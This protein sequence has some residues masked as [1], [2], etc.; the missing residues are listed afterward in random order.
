MHAKCIIPQR[1]SWLVL[2][3]LLASACVPDAA[4][5]PPAAGPAPPTD[6]QPP[7]DQQRGGD[8]QQ[9]SAAQPTAEPGAAADPQPG[10]V[11]PAADSVDP[12]A[13][14]VDPADMDPETRALWDQFTASALTWAK[15]VADLREVQIRFHNGGPEQ[16]AALRRQFQQLRAQ[17]RQE[18]DRALADAVALVAHEQGGSRVAGE[19]VLQAVIARVQQDWL[20]GIAR[21]ADLLL[22]LKVDFPGLHSA[23][24]R[25][26]VVEGQY[27]QARP[28]L[29]KAAEL[30]EQAAME[31]GKEPEDRTDAML[32]GMLAESRAQWQ[33][34]Q[35]LR[36]ADAAADDLPRVLLKTT[37]GDVVVELF[38]DQAPNTVANFI[39]L[40]EQGFY[41]ELTF[42]QVL[43]HLFALTG[44]PVGDGSGDAG[45][46]IPD[47]HDR[48]DARDVFRGSLVMAKLPNPAGGTT[49]TLPN[50]ASS[51]FMI[52]FLPLAAMSNEYTVFG[53]VIEG[54]PAVATMTRLNPHEK[55]DEGPQY[56]PDRILSAEVL[57]KRDHPYTVE[58]LPI[59]Q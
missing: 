13:G 44:D 32:L 56:P 43:D 24:G 17:G 28:F 39:T 34:E 10:S 6:Q 31:K 59:Q 27:E 15:T 49:Q 47:E 38:E 5:Q 41:D 48:A 33:R 9:P 25:G 16:A 40:V 46:R 4:A 19:F 20:E 18:Y 29:L 3:A 50:T 14:S 57:R 1:W 55:A 53:R 12:A 35:E 36:A 45:Y 21:G 30:V 58:K 52:T 26:Y 54:M 11:D 7:S 8:Q 51:Q 23:A 42:Y 37:R 2:S 22:Q